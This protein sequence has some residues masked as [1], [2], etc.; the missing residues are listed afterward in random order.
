[1]YKYTINIILDKI[2]A[3]QKIDPKSFRSL[4]ELK[5]TDETGRQYITLIIYTF[6]DIVKKI[7]Q[8]QDGKETIRRF[9]QTHNSGDVYIGYGD[10]FYGFS[11]N[12]AGFTPTITVTLYDDDI[13]ESNYVV[14]EPS[15]IPIDVLMS[16][17][18]DSGSIHNIAMS[19]MY[20]VFKKMGSR[21]INFIK[22]Y[23][24]SMLFDD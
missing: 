6:E 23:I 16:M 21:K 5:L 15:D 24:V 10:I 3:E 7:Q 8:H 12:D 14:I 19:A 18:N 4:N 1:M 9:T 13:P 11:H 22:N 2:N 20:L 17:T